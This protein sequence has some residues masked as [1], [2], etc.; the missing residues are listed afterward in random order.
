MEMKRVVADAPSD[1]AVVRRRRLV[2]LAL[3]AR[4]HDVVAADGAVV[5]DHICPT[6]QTHTNVSKI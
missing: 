5:D 4:V 1:I 2:S 3:D 6:P